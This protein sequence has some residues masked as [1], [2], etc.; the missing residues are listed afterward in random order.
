MRIASRTGTDTG[1]DILTH[2]LFEGANPEVVSRRVRHIS[3]HE[4]RAG[5]MVTR[6]EEHACLL[7][8]EGALLSYV[9]LPDGRRILFDV[10][11]SGGVDAV[12][13]AGLDVGGHF[14]EAVERSVVARLDRRVLEALVDEEPAVAQ[15]MMRLSLRRLR[16]REA[17]VQALVHHEA[18]RRVASML[19]ALISYTGRPAS[20]MDGA[21]VELSPR[22]TH[23]VLAD[24]VGLRRE[25]VTK[26]MG[27]LRHLGAVRVRP[28]ALVLDLRLLVDVVETE[29]PDRIRNLVEA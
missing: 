13:N 27:K 28:A 24:M 2:P 6:P 10:I 25:T 8:F 3:A 11:R 22:P 17:Q 20:E 4:V 14:S 21:C 9:L 12:L 16:R 23:Q 15:A 26:E 18:L 19:L 7:V 5:Q 1:R 29:I